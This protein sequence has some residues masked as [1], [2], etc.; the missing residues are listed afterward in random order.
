MAMHRFNELAF[1]VRYF[2]PVQVKETICAVNRK[3]AHGQALYAKAK[4]IFAAWEVQT[5]AVS[6]YVVVHGAPHLP[7]DLELSLYSHLVE[8]LREYCQFAL[9][10]IEGLRQWRYYIGWTSIEFSINRVLCWLARCTNMFWN[11]DEI[12]IGFSSGFC[13][14][15]F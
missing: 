10:K 12:F 14:G 9:A 5:Q 15:F 7:V 4:A 11:E 13:M 2:G 3:T 8:H 1:A 6:A